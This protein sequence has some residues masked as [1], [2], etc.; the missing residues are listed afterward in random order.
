MKAALAALEL[1]TPAQNWLEEIPHL[2][3]KHGF[4]HVRKGP[5]IRCWQPEEAQLHKRKVPFVNGFDI[6]R[7]WV[8]RGK[9]AVGLTPR[10]IYLTDEN[11]PD[12]RS[13]VDIL[14]GLDKPVTDIGKALKRQA[15]LLGLLGG[16][17]CTSSQVALKHP[18]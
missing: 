10:R 12:S 6:G 16:A 5:H 13:E 4:A 11:Q 8:G 14:G 18:F 2:L 3:T 17:Q 15:H 9:A 1:A 7:L